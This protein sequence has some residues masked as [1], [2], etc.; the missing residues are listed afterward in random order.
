MQKAPLAYSTVIPTDQI[1]FFILPALV[2]ASIFKYTYKKQHVRQN[3]TIRMLISYRKRQGE[4]PNQQ[5]KVIKKMQTGANMLPALNACK[6][7]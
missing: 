7:T 1:G 5:S 4:N 2:S 3:E 6:R